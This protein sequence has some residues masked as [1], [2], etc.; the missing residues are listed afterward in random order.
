LT[1]SVDDFARALEGQDFN[2]E[3]GTKVKG[4]PFSTSNE[5]IFVDIG[6]KAAAFLPIQEIVLPVSLEPTEVVP[7]EKER[8][9]LII[10]GQDADGQVV[11]SVRQLE[12][13]AV[14]ERLVEASE[15]KESYTVRVTGT[16][17][18]GVTVDL[19]GIRGFV[20]RSHLVDRDNLDGLVGQTINACL[21]E[22]DPD[23]NKLVLSH[24]LASQATRIQSFQLNDLVSGTVRD[25]KPFGVFVDLNGITG[26]LHIQQ[27]S[28]KYVSSL[29]GIFTRGDIVRCVV[30]DLDPQRGRVSLSTKVLEKR[31]G[32]MLDA[33]QDVYAEAEIRL[34][35]YLGE[36]EVASEEMTKNPSNPIPEDST[37]EVGDIA[38]A[39]DDSQNWA[40]RG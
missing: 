12:I 33:A 3:V 4:K 11:L 15:S 7:L 9:F 23:R 24:R 10:K 1:F 28:N 30:V 39:A 5:G 21:I 35:K 34:Q 40:A 14:W 22:V 8:E 25:L 36:A 32:E 20:P 29:D 13:K 31:P 16:N 18:G 19:Q 17:K 26:L 6:G 2:F 37:P 27:I 38:P